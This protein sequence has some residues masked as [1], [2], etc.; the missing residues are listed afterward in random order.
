MDI[1]GKAKSAADSAQDHAQGANQSRPFRLLVAIGLVAYGVVHLLVAGIALQLAWG[2]SRQNA[3][4]LGAL[5]ELADKPFGLVLLWVVIVG[6]FALVLWKVVTTASG[7]IYENNKRKRAMKR[8]A[9]AGMAVVYAA[10]AVSAIRIATGSGSSGSD[11]KSQGLTASLLSNTF[12]QVLLVIIAAAIV[13]AGAFDIRK[14]LAK[15]FK[16]DLDGG[17]SQGMVKFGQVGYAAKGVALCIVGALF[18]WAALS[19]DS[20]KAGGLDDAF[21]TVR[22]QPFGSI[23]LTLMAL[24]FVCFGIFCFGWSCHA[25]HD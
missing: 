8:A 1:T 19:H 9:A 11:Q 3:D 22:D 17:V 25:R 24:G 7:Y 13:V 20:S 10:L 23:L 2:G 4:Q 5:Q 16:N 18:G 12:G 15:K 14:G 6:L 21:R